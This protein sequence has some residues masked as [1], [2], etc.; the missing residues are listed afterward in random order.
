MKWNCKQLIHEKFSHNYYPIGIIILVQHR[1]KFRS[2][3]SKNNLVFILNYNFSIMENKSKNIKELIH[4]AV[5]NDQVLISK[6]DKLVLNIKG[7]IDG[8]KKIMPMVFKNKKCR[9]DAFKKFSIKR[10]KKII[11]FVKKI[12]M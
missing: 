6:R 5:G 8:N 4:F 3:F 2:N 10:A 9:N 11:R 12:K 1:Q 7:V